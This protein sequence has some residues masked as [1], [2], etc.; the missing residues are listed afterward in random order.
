MKTYKAVMHFSR[1]GALKSTP[2]TVHYRGKC[3][4]VQEIRCYAPMR[5]EWKPDKKSNP[6]AFF[7]AFTHKLIIEDGVAILFDAGHWNPRLTKG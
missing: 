5:S 3:H 4:I 1:P 2:W 7:V 6:R